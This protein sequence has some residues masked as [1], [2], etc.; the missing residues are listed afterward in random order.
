MTRI[1]TESLPV[2]A[3]KLRALEKKTIANIIESGRL[4]QVAFDRFEHG[5]R[6]EYNQWIETEIG[7]S[8]RQAA[9]YR[10]VYGFSQICQIGKFGKRN[11]ADLNISKTAIYMLAEEWPNDQMKAAIKEVLKLASKSRM[12]PE[13]V[14]AIFA[15][16]AV[17]EPTDVEPEPADVIPEHDVEPV[18]A[19]PEPDVD[20][21]DAE[22]DDAPPAPNELTRALEIIGTHNVYSL[23]WPSAAKLIDAVELQGIID[24]LQ[25][26]ASQ[27]FGSDA[28]KVKADRAEARSRATQH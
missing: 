11:I 7:W 4:L 1:N 13:T 14:S 3:G 23:L 12:T 24:T 8:P 25:A 26:V 9:R 2:L 6:D 16:H 17:L 20:E 21:P 22:A 27:Y 28:L 10:N 15:K 18:D 5:D 19:A